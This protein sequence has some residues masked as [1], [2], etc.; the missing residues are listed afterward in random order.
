M[1]AKR[2]VLFVPS[3]QEVSRA[4]VGDK[5][6]GTVI[7]WMMTFI[8]AATGDTLDSVWWSEALDTGDKGI[9]KAA[10]QGV[11]YFLLKFFLAGDDQ[12]SDET[13]HDIDNIAPESDVEK[14]RAY[15]VDTLGIAWEQALADAHVDG[16]IDEPFTVAELDKL[17][18]LAKELSKKKASPKIVRE[19]ITKNKG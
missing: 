14:C 19:P 13:S 4:P 3:M 10:T 16:S 9:N 8:D 5:S 6:T 17:R 12:D 1:L 2:G 11:K 18:A 7:R 15:F